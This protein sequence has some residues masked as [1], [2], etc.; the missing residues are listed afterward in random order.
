[1]NLFKKKKKLKYIIEV[2]H[3]NVIKETLKGIPNAH[4]VISNY[5]GKDGE[6][7]KIHKI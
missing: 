5:K 1:M 4:I 2:N 7:I 6:N 3:H